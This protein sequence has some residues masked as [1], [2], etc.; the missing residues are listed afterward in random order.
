MSAL[1]LVLISVLMLNRTKQN[2]NEMTI[3][4]L[5]FASFPH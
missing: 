1:I 4:I 3:G 2:P 5:Q